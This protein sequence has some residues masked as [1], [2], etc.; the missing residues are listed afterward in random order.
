AEGVIEVANANMER[1]L[2][3]I[4]VERGHDPGDYTLFAFGGAGGLHAAELAE[5][6]SIPRAF[7]PRNAGAISALGAGLTDMTKSLTQTA[8]IEDR[9]AEEKSL[10]ELFDRLTAEG[11]SQFLEDGVDAGSFVIERSLFIR[12][13]GQSYELRV[14][15]DGS[16]NE[17]FARFDELHT[18][19]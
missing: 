6:L 2:R 9:N 17:A 7:I 8:L 14:K 5:R 10:N 15:F 12:Y 16:L 19:Y 4:T 3:S 1:I 18:Q 11:K 13:K